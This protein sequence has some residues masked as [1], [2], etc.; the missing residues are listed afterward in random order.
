MHRFKESYMVHIW[1]AL[2]TFAVSLASATSSGPDPWP[3]DPILY[4]SFDDIANDFF[5]DPTSL[6]LPPYKVKLQCSSAVHLRQ[7]FGVPHS[8]A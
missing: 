5:N 1:Y 4:E 7:L 6:Q 3:A 2:C 8:G